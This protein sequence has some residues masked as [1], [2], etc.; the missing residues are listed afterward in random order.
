MSIRILIALASLLALTHPA[1]AKRAPGGWLSPS[2]YSAM[3]AVRFDRHRI[4]ASTARGFADPKTGRAVTIDDPVRVASISK[5]LV[6]LAV[7]RLVERKKLDLDADVSLALGWRVRNPAFPDT[8]ITLRLLLSHRS[9]LTDDADYLIGLDDSVA[10]RLDD[11]KVW[12]ASHLPGSYFRYTNLNFPVIAT[13]MER[14]TGE[15]FDRL[16]ARLV[17]KPLHLDAC[18]NWTTCSDK[19]VARAVVLIAADGSVRRDG[20]DGVRPACPVIPAG[21]GSCNLAGYAIGTN[22]GLFSP[23]GGARISMVDLARVG[24]MLLAGGRGFLKV[25]SLRQMTVPQW[26]YN[27]QNGETEKGFWCAY[28]LGVQTLAA[29]PDLCRDDPFGDKTIR[30]GHPGEAY[31]LRSGLWIDPKAHTGIAF[32]MTAV[33]DTEPTGRSA[34]TLA[35]EMIMQEQP[36]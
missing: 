6:T 32:F 16:M 10:H 36:R 28:G 20:L 27:G 3:V 7:M 17:F 1:M 2:R 22:G 29:N 11:P 9:S 24:Q 25:T 12:D 34:F 13:I 21:D 19:Q 18:F 26:Q 23:Q 30:I 4:I 15:R 31:G 14:Q 35:E 33:P 5:L 8:P